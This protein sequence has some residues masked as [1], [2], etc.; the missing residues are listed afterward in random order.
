VISANFNYLFPED[1]Q[2]G[3]VTGLILKDVR[4]GAIYTLSSGAPLFD[5]IQWEGGTYFMS[6][7]EDVSWLTRRAGKLVGGTFNFFRGRWVQNLNLRL[8][9][10]FRLGGARRLSLF[11]EIFNALNRKL[12]TPYPTGSGYE[13]EANSHGPTGGVDW[14]WEERDD[15]ERIKFNA[16]FNGDGVLA[17]EEA[18][19][20]QIAYSVMMNTMDKEA[21]GLARQIRLG[22]EFSF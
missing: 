5:R 1:F 19:K 3:T 11:G 6:A 4:I 7:H 8:T 12:H 14:I 10:S 9:K 22:V 18:T 15:E 2:V 13:W 21:W 17:V 20:G 16:D